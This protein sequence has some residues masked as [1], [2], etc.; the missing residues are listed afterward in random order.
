MEQKKKYFLRLIPGRKYIICQ[1]IIGCILPVN[2]EVAVGFAVNGAFPIKVVN[3]LPTNSI[4]I[5]SINLSMY[6]SM[7]LFRTI[8]ILGRK[9]R[10]TNEE[11]CD[12][13]NSFHKI[14]FW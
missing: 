2:A 5:F 8:K 4:E 12:S 9:E 6:A 11:Q 7:P 1:V 14:R 13:V 10:Q 3:A